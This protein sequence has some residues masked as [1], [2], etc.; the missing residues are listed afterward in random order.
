L[1]IDNDKNLWIE[2]IGIM[3]FSAG[4]HLA[5][6]AVTHFNKSYI[7]NIENISLKPYFMM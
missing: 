6:T 4:G 3:G 1:V 2:K 7:S 5:S